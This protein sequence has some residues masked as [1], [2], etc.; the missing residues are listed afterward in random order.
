[1]KN[2]C[3]A[4]SGGPTAVINESARA[5]IQ[6]AQQHPRQFGRVYAGLN[7]I[8]GILNENLI[9]TY[10]EP[11]ENI[12]AL[13]YTPGAAFGSCRY[14]LKDITT[15]REEYL[16]LLDVFDAHN[17]GYFLY[18][19]GGDSQDTAYKIAQISTSLGYPLQCI[20]IPKTV[21]NDLPFTDCSPGFASAGKYLATSI[22]EAGLDLASMASSSTR[23]FIMETMGRHTGWL[24][25]ASGI[26]QDTDNPEPHIILFPEVPF[27]KEKFI[28]KVDECVKKHGLCTISV[29]EGIRDVHGKHLCESSETDAF[30]HEQLGGVASIISHI[31]KQ[32]LKLKNH[33]AVPDYFQRAGRHLASKVDLDHA[34]AVG[35]SAVEFLLAGKHAVMPTII[36]DS[37]SPYRW[38]ISDAQL[39]DIANQE[40]FLP[41]DY[42]DAE[43]FHISDA[44]REYLSP[45]MQGVEPPIFHHGLPKYVRLQKKIV[46]KKLQ[47]LR[48]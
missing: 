32:E 6:T 42:I 33:W 4:Q 28:A 29:S 24:A 17:I 30:G 46:D 10:A 22:R 7:G 25:A 12:D 18:N 23:V 3:Y 38:H 26:A 21:D 15:H 13:R 8:S 20:G 40:K 34:Y 16:R 1:M 48:G 37:S 36:R 31:V 11:P 2:I 44:C 41:L 19:G 39:A 35:K 14:K 9:D 47:L 45:L 5:V 27:V 43:G